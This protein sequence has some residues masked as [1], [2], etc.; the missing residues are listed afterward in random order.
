[1][2]IKEAAIRFGV[3]F[4]AGYM[5][6]LLIRSFLG[7]KASFVEAGVVGAL[8]GSACGAYPPLLPYC[9]VV[10]V[11]SLSSS[12]LGGWEAPLAGAAGFALLVLR[13]KGVKQKG[14]VKVREPTETEP[15]PS[16]EVSFPSRSFLPTPPPQREETR[17]VEHDV[18]EEAFV[19]VEQVVSQV[20]LVSSSAKL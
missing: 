17:E 14:E 13:G 15:R 7:G 6:L 2:E 4:L 8:L 3:P 18:G 16:V 12:L 11:S 5:V 10:V 9:G 1:M 20:R 19:P